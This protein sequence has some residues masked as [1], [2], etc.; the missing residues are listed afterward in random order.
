MVTHEQFII[1]T[2]YY[3]KEVFEKAMERYE[4]Y[5]EWQDYFFGEEA[6]SFVRFPLGDFDTVVGIINSIVKK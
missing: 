6:K 2:M 1:K 5:I 3:N 4:K